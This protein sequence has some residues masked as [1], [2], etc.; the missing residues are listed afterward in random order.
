MTDL[1][2]DQYPIRVKLI[3]D[4][5]RGRISSS[6]GSK[7]RDGP[8]RLTYGRSHKGVVIIGF[9]T[10]LFSRSVSA[11]RVHGVDPTVS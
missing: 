5:L 8:H 3:P 10:S 9:W 6:I 11:S 4:P 1:T 2:V 7:L